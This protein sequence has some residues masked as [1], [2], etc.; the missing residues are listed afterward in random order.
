M[1]PLSDLFSMLRLK[2]ARCTRFEA[3]GAWALRLPAK[4]ALKF[5]AVLRGE[6][7]LILPGMEP[8]RLRAGDTF[9]LANAPS[10]VLANDRE[11]APGD[12]IELFDWEHS[13]IAHHQ[14][15]D[16]VLVAGSFLFEA[17]DAQS[18]LETLP[19]F[20]LIP[21][22]DA[23]ST[24]LRA[25]LA[26]LDGEIRSTRMGASLVTSR[27]ADI[28]LVQA[29]RAYVAGEGAGSSGWI[30]AL[31]DPQIGSAL[32]LMHNQVAE[33]WTVDGLAS[34]VGMSRSAFALRFKET[35]GVTPLDYLLRWRMQLARDA[36]RRRETVSSIAAATG[37]ASESA[38][39][40]AFKRVYGRAPKRYWSA[41]PG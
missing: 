7:W 9:L 13:D 25:T 21:A 30:G 1:D 22:S 32:S 15:D 18:L 26:I 19:S 10:Y 5:A 3:G 24:V 8:H 17:A 38:F 12:G 34:A 41:S 14:G 6:C 28:L 2:S 40:N 27:L 20:M 37:Y 36:L 4:P 39:G 35:V 11:M 29:L 23:A 16:T 33:R 31:A